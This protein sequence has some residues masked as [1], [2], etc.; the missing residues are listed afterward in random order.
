MKSLRIKS[1]WLNKT[2]TQNKITI[3]TSL[4]S[5]SEYNFYN[6]N[7]FDF[8]FEPKVKIVHYK[9]KKNKKKDERETE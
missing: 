7:G 3:D 9:N 6:D 4:I 2:L 8:I 5:E 1:E